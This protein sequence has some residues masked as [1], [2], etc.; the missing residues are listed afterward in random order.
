M[1]KNKQAGPV[2]IRKKEDRPEA[3]DYSKSQTRNQRPEDFLR[4]TAGVLGFVTQASGVQF[5]PAMNVQFSAGVD[6]SEVGK[7]S[8]TIYSDEEAGIHL[9]QRMMRRR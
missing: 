3:A 6:T 4:S 8:T 1:P 9:R 5:S 7:T 2:V